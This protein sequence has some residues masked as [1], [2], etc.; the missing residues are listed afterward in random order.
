LNRKTLQD[1]PS[2]PIFPS[3]KIGDLFLDTPVLLAPM[4]GITDRSFRRVCR[5]LGA[6]M[7][8]TELV[9]AEAI[10]R[11][12]EK[13][14]NLARFNSEERPIGIQ[15]FSHDPKVLAQ[16]ASRLE[17]LEPDVVDLNFG[18][19]VKKVV[20]RGAGAGFLSDLER[21]SDAVRE[22]VKSTSRP[23][24][25]KLRS[26]PSANLINAVEAAKRAEDEGARAVI[27]H[28]RTARQFFQG[29]ADWSVIASVKRALAVPVI[30]NGDIKS[31]EDLQRMLDQTGCDGVMIGRGCL[32]NPWIFRA[33]REVL[34]GETPV[35][36]DPDERWV[37]IEDH[38]RRMIAD[39]GV[40]VGVR[41]MRKHLGWY[42]RGMPGAAS[43]RRTV[44][45]LD[46]PN[47]VLK[48]CRTFFLKRQTVGRAMG[49]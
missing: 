37:V 33:C 43:F 11:G 7:V 26:G 9:A 10:V 49:E 31:P 12:Q 8:F 20:R 41:E 16:A 44:F 13:T 18:C 42:S 21:L 28:A 29:E 17:E 5:R 34:R 19:P 25:V 32:G 15:L 48:V 6:G 30:G 2:D 46:D 27:V 47:E 23:V 38:Y 1:H 35:P 24:T 3:L 36:P 39:K 22:V 4:A 45:R 40:A 14:W